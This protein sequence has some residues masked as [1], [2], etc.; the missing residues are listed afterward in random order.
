MDSFAANVIEIT[1]D[2]E[3]VESY[4][5]TLHIQYAANW[6]LL[7][8]FNENPDRKQQKMEESNSLLDIVDTMQSSITDLGKLFKVSNNDHVLT[9]L[10]YEF[11]TKDICELYSLIKQDINNQPE[12]VQEIANRLKG[13]T[14]CQQLLKNVMTK[15]CTSFAFE[16]NEI[17]KQWRDFMRQSNFS[18]DNLISI[19][20]TQE[21]LDINYA[22]PYIYAL[23]LYDVNLMM[24]ASEN[25]FL[26]VRSE[27]V[28]WFVITLIFITLLLSVP[29]QQLISHLNTH[30]NACF[31]LIKIF[32]YAMISNNK[33]LENKISRITKQQKI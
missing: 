23:G 28:V 22:L 6:I 1:G 11:F 14:F 5:L 21:F 9:Q 13:I 30:S 25:Y 12:E 20:K 29:Y 19:I 16:I 10:K 26:K 18:S 31:E 2:L 17:F 24:S 32:P 7:G 15:G 33:L 8:L 4:V 3:S 27:Q